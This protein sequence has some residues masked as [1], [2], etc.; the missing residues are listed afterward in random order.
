MPQSPHSQLGT[1]RAGSS[2]TA[3]PQLAVIAVRQ[4]HGPGVFRFRANQPE[5]GAEADTG[6]TQK[7][8]QQLRRLP[9]SARK[10]TDVPR[11][12]APRSAPP[13]AFPRARVWRPVMT[14]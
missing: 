3:R 4:R 14:P 9:T 6:A 1:P 11:R 10:A 5:T 13:P 7:A 2:L 8:N 12:A